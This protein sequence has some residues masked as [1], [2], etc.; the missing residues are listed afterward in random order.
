MKIHHVGYLAKNLEK[1]RN[2]YVEL[3]FVVERPAKYDEIRKVNIEFLINGD[4]RVELIEPV[5]KDSPMYPLLT[6]Y[7]NTPY[8]FCYEVDNLDKAITELSDKH[9]T[10][11]QEPEVAPCI[12]ND[13]VVF[14]YNN[15]IG[16]IE[17]V[18]INAG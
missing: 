10:I 7:K 5:D 8:H 2:K 13:R 3:G 18:E 14:M 17:L 16:I 6:R 11:M 9:Y 4:Y 1:S 12:D 15:S